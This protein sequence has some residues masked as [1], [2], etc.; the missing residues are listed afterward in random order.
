MAE[1][2]IHK[3]VSGKYV[4]SNDG[5]LHE[6]IDFCDYLVIKEGLFIKSKHGSAENKLR[7]NRNKYK[8]E[9][10]KIIENYVED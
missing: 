1:N 2:Y 6:G 10:N 3:K 8:T 9:T 4:I 5:L 7:Y